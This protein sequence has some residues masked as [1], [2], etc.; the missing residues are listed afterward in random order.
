VRVDDNARRRIPPLIQ[1]RAVNCPV[2]FW[3]GGSGRGEGDIKSNGAGKA[4]SGKPAAA[5]MDTRG[6]AP[7]LK[8]LAFFSLSA[9]SAVFK[10][11]RV[12][13]FVVHSPCGWKASRA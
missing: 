10:S 11:W 7:K 1:R 8:N 6:E 4:A 12:R 9:V 5:A 13:I 3:P 2:A